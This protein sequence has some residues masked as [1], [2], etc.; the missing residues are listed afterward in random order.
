[1]LFR[2]RRWVDIDVHAVMTTACDLMKDLRC[3]SQSEFVVEGMMKS[4]TASGDGKTCATGWQ[5]ISGREEYVVMAMQDAD[6][7]KSDFD[8]ADGHT[9][10]VVMADDGKGGTVNY[11]FNID[12][13]RADV[14][15]QMAVAPPDKP[16]PAAAAP[17][18]A[19]APAA[20]PPAPRR[21]E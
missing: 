3:S 10:Q 5:V 15:A 11:Y 18:S 8:Q 19:A 16:A 12:L 7:K 17:V 9:C 1:M 21:Q 2:S 6:V 4:I 20:P 14:S 13:I